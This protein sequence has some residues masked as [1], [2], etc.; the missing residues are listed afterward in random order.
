IWNP[1]DVGWEEIPVE[2]RPLVQVA[3]A[4]FASD[5]WTHAVFTL[6]N[7]NNDSR[8]SAGTLYLNGERAGRIEGW[9]MTLDWAADEVELVLG[10]AYVGHLDDVAVFNRTL[11]GAEV[12][13][14]YR[15]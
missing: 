8:P 9:D 3:D 6:R 14:L 1:K 11:T 12:K 5:K 2:K 10:A 4:P 13:Q 7:I 15:L